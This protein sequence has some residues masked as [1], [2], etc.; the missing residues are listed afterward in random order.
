M[1]VRFTPHYKIQDHPEY[2]PDPCMFNFSIH[3]EEERYYMG[4]SRR[5]F[6]TA[7][8]LGGT[9]GGMWN[10]HQV[11]AKCKY[12]DNFSRKS[13]IMSCFSQLVNTLLPAADGSPV[14]ITSWERVISPDAEMFNGFDV[15]L[16]TEDQLINQSDTLEDGKPNPAYIIYTERKPRN[17]NDLEGRELYGRL[18]WL[19]N[20]LRKLPTI[21]EIAE[22]EEERTRRSEEKRIAATNSTD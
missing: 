16:M 2:T 15:H 21:R 1:H 10:I 6:M 17:K 13:G 20:R 11:T 19:D 5:T 12:G 9:Y 22:Q 3:Y 7:V 14:W 4:Y 18:W 8:E